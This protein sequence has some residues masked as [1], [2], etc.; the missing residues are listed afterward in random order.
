MSCRPYLVSPAQRRA[1]NLDSA[2]SWAPLTSPTPVTAAA[3][4]VTARSWVPLSS[5]ALVSTAKAEAALRGA[6]RE[7]VLSSSASGSSTHSRVMNADREQQPHFLY[8]DFDQD[9]QGYS[10][11]PWT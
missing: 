2:S 8:R 10:R 7:N 9:D 4:G 5:P 1:Q 3:A 6:A 11:H